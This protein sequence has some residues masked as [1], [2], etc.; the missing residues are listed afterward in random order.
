MRYAWPCVLE[1]D[2]DDARFINASFPDIPEAMTC[3]TSQ[4]E[5]LAQ[6]TDA[7]AAALAGYVGLRRAIPPPGT[8]DEG[9]HMVAVPPVVAA[10]L[11]L[12]TAM[13]TQGVSKVALAALLGVSEA[14]VRKLTNPDHRSHISQVERALKILGRTLVLEDRVA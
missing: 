9:R 2:E 10:K 12:Y 6:A 7:L 11:A 4:E 8:P 13:R 14:A 3:A 1:E 5:A